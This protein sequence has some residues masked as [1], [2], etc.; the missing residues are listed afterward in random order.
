MKSHLKDTVV[1]TWTTTKM[2][3]LDTEFWNLFVY[4][5]LIIRNYNLKFTENKEH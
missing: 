1:D 2:K 4:F 3:I 5:F